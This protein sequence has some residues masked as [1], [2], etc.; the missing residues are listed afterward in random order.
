MMSKFFEKLPRHIFIVCLA[1]VA[2]GGAFLYGAFAHSYDLPPIPQLKVAYKTITTPGDI[3]LT[4]DP[5]REHLQ[6]SRGQGHGVTV[7][8]TPNDG[9][10]VLMAGFFDDENQIR[11]I[12]R[13]GTLVKKWS[14]DYLKHFPD[15]V[16]RECNPRSPLRVDTHGAL[17]TPE[18]EV[19]F[20]YEYCGT[21]KLDQCGGLVWTINKETHHSVVPA[22]SGGYWLLGRIRW[23]PSEQPDRFPPFSTTSVTDQA[24]KED[25]LLRVS[26]KGEILEEVSIPELMR[27][28]NLEALL[29]ANGKPFDLRYFARNELVHANK[30]AE[31]PSKIAGF[32]PLFAAGDLVISMKDHNFIMVLDPVTK[33]V[34]WHQTG[35]WIRQH[36]PEFRSD[37]RISIFNNNVYGTAY[38]N[39]QTVLSTP[40]TTNII[41]V[42]PVSRETEV[43]FGERPGQEM[44]SVI[45]G[46]HQLLENNGML[47]TEFDAGRVLEVDEDGQIVWEYV[48]RFN[49]DFVGEITNSAIYPADYFQGE[50][51]PC[52][53]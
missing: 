18:G 7:N 53:Q 51:K 37:G 1:L 40:Y 25:M 47:I 11:L 10:L 36:D 30:V 14:L 21:V 16:A 9:A 35:P 29:T 27:A 28:N 24:I 50:W 45:R 15:A 20:N 2:L 43:I 23:W 39:R 22:E 13:D 26:E 17:A 4:D 33:K 32:Y 52:G 48:N 41:A 44:L 31:L 3:D 19:V 49:E 6:P 5:R 12:K 46:D 8:K 38:V 42:D 34:K